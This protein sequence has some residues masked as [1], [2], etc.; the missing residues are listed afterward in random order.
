[1]LNFIRCSFFLLLLLPTI[2]FS[3]ESDYVDSGKAET[4]K[5]F[6]FSAGYSLGIPAGDYRDI[7]DSTS[8][9]ILNFTGRL[10]D[11]FSMLVD[12]EYAPYQYSGYDDTILT[13]RLMLGVSHVFKTDSGA[14]I[15]PFVA[16]GLGVKAGIINYIYSSY[17]SYWED[18]IDVNGICGSFSGG[19]RIFFV[20]N[21]FFELAGTYDIGAKLSNDSYTNSDIDASGF[22]INFKL[23]FAF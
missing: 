2:A 6:L 5:K 19:A 15:E 18:T 14:K 12:I 7:V 1:M 22:N 11:T 4:E 20:E 10:N 8:G 9:F 17:Y 3:Q 21:F 16:A 23:G 13:T